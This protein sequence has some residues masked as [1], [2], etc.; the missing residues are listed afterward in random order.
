MF[1]APDRATY[2]TYVSLLLFVL[3]CGPKCN[4]YVS[5][6][7]LSGPRRIEIH[8]ISKLICSFATA[9]GPNPDLQE[10]PWSWFCHK[11][12]RTAIQS[13]KFSYPQDLAPESRNSYRVSPRHGSLPS[14]KHRY[15]G[16]K[17]SFPR[18]KIGMAPWMGRLAQRFLPKSDLWMPHS[19][20]DCGKFKV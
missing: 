14:I 1:L 19:N 4:T 18:V 13:Y 12:P 8:Y 3:P 6:F 17:S 7:A 20:F 2:I 16:S 10:E 11:V 15:K 5:Y 9:A